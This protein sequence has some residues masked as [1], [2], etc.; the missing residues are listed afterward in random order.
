MEPA[1]DNA[2]MGEAQ[3]MET[4]EP[5]VNQPQN[6]DTGVPPV[7]ED[8]SKSFNFILNS[9]IL[10]KIGELM[11]K[12]CT[13]CENYGTRSLVADPIKKQG[14][15]Q[16]IVVHV[17]IRIFFPVKGLTPKV[18]FLLLISTLEQ[19]YVFENLDSEIPQL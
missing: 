17:E 8:A 7:D 10:V 9:D 6:N 14:L 3:N 19:R 13:D 11:N 1:E 18:M 12:P 16:L 5:H 15:S 2:Q 4:S